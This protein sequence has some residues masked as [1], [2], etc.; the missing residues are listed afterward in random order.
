[1]NDQTY[2][3]SLAL[4][5]RCPFQ[6]KNKVPS[7]GNPKLC[8]YILMGEAPGRNEVRK[9]KPF[10][11]DTGILLAAFLARVD[12]KLHSD[13][14]YLMN[15]LS[16]SVRGKTKT[17]RAVTACRP[18]VLAELAEINPEATLVLM[19][20]NAREVLYPGEKGGILGS[21]GWRRWKGRDVY[22]MAHPSYYL[23]NPDQAPMLVKDVMRVKRG[24]LPQIGPF[25]KVDHRGDDL[26]TIDHLGYTYSVLDTYEKLD[27]LISVLRNV[28]K[29]NRGFLAYDIESDQVDYQ[30]DRI[31][32]V[33][34]STCSGRAYIIPDSLLYEDAHEFVT[35]DWS[36]QKWAGFVEDWRYLTGSYLKPDS[37][38]VALLRVLFGL[39]G[40]K[41][42]AHNSKFDMRFLSHLGVKNI[43]CDFDTIN[44]HYVL[45][46]R[47]GG[48]GLKALSDDYFDVGDYE[49][50]LFQ[51]IV[52]KSA[53][54]SRIPRAVLYRY[55]AMDTECTLRLARTL[56]SELKAEGLY[57]WPFKNVLMAAL[58][59]LLE[60]ELAGVE[61]D[62]EEV[63]R[64]EVDELLPEIEK[65]QVEL[66]LIC[67]HP[68][69]NP[70]SSVKVNNILYDEFKMPLVSART[71]A[72]GRRVGGRSSQ[73]AI[74]DAWAKMQER[75]ELQ[76]SEDAQRFIKTL[77]QYRHLRKLL[78][79]YVRKWRKFRGTDNR[80]HTSYHLRGTVTGRLSSTDPP[81]QTIPSKITDRWGPLIANMHIAKP[82]WK[83][84]YGDYSQ[85]ELMGVAS[86]SGDKFMIE[87][88]QQEN[89][90]YHSIVAQAA[91]GD[92]FTRDQRQ[93]S[94]KL[95][96]GWL[97]GGNVRGIALDALQFDGAVAERF[98][99]EWDDLFQEVGRWRKK[100]A[101]HMVKHGYVE[102]IF[103]RRRRRVLLTD[104][105]IGKAK[106]I[107]V[108]SPIQSAI[109]DFNLLSA[110]KLYHRFKGT[111]YARVVLLI[112][113][114]LIMEV[115]EDKLEEVSK[116]MHEIM[117][118]TPAKYIKEFPFKVDLKYSHQLGDLT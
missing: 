35:T 22:I 3:D 115:R 17:P 48:H 108:N 64:I 59:M 58:P 80:V 79:S 23:Y 31:M 46:E 89:A 82:G 90:D 117:L 96:F 55:N 13:D 27:W 83:L 107:A 8:K 56:E 41:W 62:W 87:A 34:I 14:F 73:K 26:V 92:D 70:L 74:M 72:G 11:G 60:A 24:R 100:Q 51:Y 15:A 91:F 106:R 36:K 16:C 109:S 1:M 40:Y 104:K 18:R 21:R 99:H 85:A 37:K 10:L 25:E 53:H 118:E 102:S 2:I 6:T 78:G 45:D 28:P 44:A 12:L 111:D 95:T 54:Y 101:A 63:D 9:G 84:L 105:N 71:R 67:G 43:R 57:E 86:F 110:V 66:R 20:R 47:K 93:A 33:S 5:D 49:S 81:M 30:R 88:F 68:D 42:A 98:A 65:L 77:A 7:S 76:V 39:S 113:D 112:H 4:C 29:K 61:I 75:G 114:S 97:Y 50:D 52:K 103:G 19:G 38:T 32:C 69:L 94:K 116:I